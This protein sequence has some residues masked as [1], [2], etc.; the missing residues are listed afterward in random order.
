MEEV[1]K[2]AQEVEAKKKRKQD[3]GKITMDQTTSRSNLLEGNNR[4]Q[5]IFLLEEIL[6]K[7]GGT[8]PQAQ[9]P[10]RPTPSHL[11]YPKLLDLIAENLQGIQGLNPRHSDAKNRISQKY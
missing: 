4:E 2:L 6:P 11:V 5:P 8:V 10:N 7:F 1:D 9:R 3:K